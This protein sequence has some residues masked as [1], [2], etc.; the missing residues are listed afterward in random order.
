MVGHL[1]APAVAAITAR[2]FTGFTEI[3][4]QAIPPITKGENILVIAPTGSGKTETA[5]LPILSRIL[6]AKKTSEAKGEKLKGI[7]AIY[8]TPLR[9]LNR[10]LML[11]FEK[12]CKQLEISIAVRHGDTTATERAK[13]RD[14]PPLFLITTPETLQSLLIAPL[15]SDALV[16]VKQ[17]V[18]DEIHELYD[19]KR[20]VQLG[21]GLARLEEKTP[22]FQRIGLS[23]TIGSPEEVA[24]FLASD[25]KVCN[26]EQKR[27]LD[28]SVEYVT[29]PRGIEA[30]K[31]KAQLHLPSTTI[32]RMQRIE[33]IIHQ[34]KSAL[35]FVNTRY[36][37]ESIAN[38]LY[39][40]E[41]LKHGVSVHHSSLSK[42]VRIETERQ[43]KEQEVKAI[44]CTSSL[45]LGI[46]IGT[47]EVVVQ[48]GSPRHVT[49]LMQRIGRS[50]HKHFLQPKGIILPTDEVD[51]AESIALCQQAQKGE[52]EKPDHHFNALDVLA[53]FIAGV[54][55]EYNKIQIGRVLKLAQ[56]AYSYQ[57][58]T[59][60]DLRGVCQQLSNNGIITIIEDKPD[61]TSKENS[62]VYLQTKGMRTKLYYYENVSTI[63]DEKRFFVKDS[64]TRKNVAVL[65]EAFVSEFIETGGI[66]IAQGRSWKVLSMDERE[67]IVEAAGQITAAIPDWVGE[68]IPVTMQTAKRVAEIIAGRIEATTCGETEKTVLSEFQQTQAK[69]F[70]PG[71]EIVVEEN[72]E[73]NVMIIHSFYG[74]RANET[75]ARTLAFMLSQRDKT[76]KTR[77]SP[78]SIVLEFSRPVGGKEIT[79]VLKKLDGKTVEMVLK[80]ALPSTRLFRH[81]FIHVAKRF[82]FLSRKWDASAASMSR[83]IAAFPTSNSMIKETLSELLR[84]RLSLEE[85]MQ[86]AEEIAN[87]NITVKH[88]YSKK[89]SPLAK[90]AL[91]MGGMSELISP[92]A[93][94]EEVLKAFAES[95][96]E[97]AVTLYCNYCKNNSTLL[98][99][100]LKL[101]DT[102][103][104]GN[105]KSNQVTLNDYADKEHVKEAVKATALISAY[106]AKALYALETY[107]VGPQTA[108]RVLARL[109]KTEG[110]FFTDLLDSQKN[111]IK[112]KKYWK[113]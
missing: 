12:W 20:G 98:L 39:A 70:L 40:V 86:V 22:H 62:Q 27:K 59:L 2:E 32:S 6:E 52:L 111:F 48:Y 29:R 9:A 21:L 87:Q 83:I 5:L 88:V 68:E 53:H 104:C 58:L 77:A 51:I 25:A 75:L 107:G 54:L 73:E 81:K 64:A 92:A 80:S 57:N 100:D 26:T 31:L 113:I 37:A 106:G 65:D 3:Q 19:T 1:L 89:W 71:N 109:H 105:C 17:V 110:E 50:G 84:S 46:D 34:H 23:A 60:V 90:S 108:G 74:L 13:Q 42:E 33:E 16:N 28:L 72:V 56:K 96:K 61:N 10:D 67:V 78:Y 82:G 103:N 15:L 79:E 38:G 24:K 66:F 102:I 97:K 95:L 11:R 47:I 85:A 7:Q 44:V 49:R 112:N 30:A 36:A 91:D 14:N 41:S 4:K 55:V 8:I 18:I 93:P 35:I 69:F 101:N 94:T 76:L 43:F 45:E 99:N 63:P